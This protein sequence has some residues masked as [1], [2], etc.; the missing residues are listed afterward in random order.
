MFESI[1]T[2]AGKFGAGSEF[3]FQAGA[4]AAHK[5]TDFATLLAV[6]LIFYFIKKNSH[7]HLLY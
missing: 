7:L 1:G 6:L 3:F 2:G 4:G 5:S